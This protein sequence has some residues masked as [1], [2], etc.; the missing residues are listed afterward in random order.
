MSELIKI[1]VVEL[2]SLFFQFDELMEIMNTKTKPP[3]RRGVF[4]NI[5]EFTLNS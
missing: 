5:L 1:Y 3:K 2:I 4:Y